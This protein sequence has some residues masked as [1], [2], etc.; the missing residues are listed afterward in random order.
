MRVTGPIGE[1][2]VAAVDGDPADDLTLEA[3]RSRYR[4]RGPQRRDLVKLR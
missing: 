2:V 1:G 4:Q 3:H